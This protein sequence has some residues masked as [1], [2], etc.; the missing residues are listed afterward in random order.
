[1]AAETAH[2]LNLTTAARQRFD[3]AINTQAYLWETGI[4]DMGIRDMGVALNGANPKVSARPWITCLSGGA[5]STALALLAEDHARRNARAHSAIIIDHGIRP[6]A[7]QEA[8]RVGRRMQEAGIA[9]T[10]HKVAAAA[11]A[12]GVQAW[13]RAQRYAIATDIARRSG[14]A[15]LLGQHAGDQAETVWMRLQR[16]SG[17]AGLGGMRA[18]D[19]RGGVPVLRP[20]L[21]FFRH[22]L[23]AV[24]QQAGVGWETD[25]SNHD[26]RFE[27]VRVRAALASL[28]GMDDQLRRLAAAASYID[29]HLMVAVAASQHAV[30]LASDGSAMLDRSVLDLPQGVFRRVLSRVTQIVGGNP[31][32]PTH[33]ALDRLWTRLQ[34]GSAS[35]LGACRFRHMA[36][37][38]WQIIAEVGRNPPSVSVR[39]GETILF[40]GR[41]LVTSQIDGMVRPC[42]V[43]SGQGDAGWRG[44][45]SWKGLS[46]AVRAPLPVVESLDG[47]PVY[48][49]LTMTSVRPDTGLVAQAVFLPFAEGAAT[50]GL[51]GSK[52]SCAVPEAGVTR[53]QGAGPDIN[54][55]HNTA[56]ISAFGRSMGPFV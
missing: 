23:D 25:P 37:Q 10:V 47:T 24:C 2:E 22:Q 12:T 17:L 41:W 36:G 49:H 5:D 19:W 6:E 20:L 14:A 18:V 26:R 30:K 3:A 32:P 33:V 54:P 38:G 56:P 53:N 21:G 16:G 11:P 42:C 13:A 52:S 7:A 35:T 31:H 43:L 40:A 15:L 44:L 1:M 55:A 8:A 46:A 45:S 4:R 39:A 9:V 27:R 29:D 34:A 50:R 48:P 28:T 51:A